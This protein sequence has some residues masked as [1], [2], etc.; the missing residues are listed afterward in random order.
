MREIY[1]KAG[2]NYYGDIYVVKN[3]EDRSSE[4]VGRIFIHI[5]VIKDI[6]DIL[7]DGEKFIEMLLS[8]TKNYKRKR[9]L[10]INGFS[11]KTTKVK[12]IY[13]WGSLYKQ[14]VRNRSLSLNNNKICDFEWIRNDIKYA[15]IL[16]KNINKIKGIRIRFFK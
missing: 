3:I 15:P 16:L 10:K 7:D 6:K 4:Q 14:D 9:D 5:V 11:D 12:P 13:I 2:L 8:V 1:E